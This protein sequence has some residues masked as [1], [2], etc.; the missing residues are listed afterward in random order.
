[1]SRMEGEGRPSV[2]KVEGEGR[3]SV[4]RVEGEGRPSGTRVGQGALHQEPLSGGG[5]LDRPHAP[6]PLAERKGTEGSSAFCVGH[7]DSN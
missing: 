3:P 6:S 7:G 5:L 1:M 2:T 4:S